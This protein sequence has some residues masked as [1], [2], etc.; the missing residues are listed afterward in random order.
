MKN[1]AILVIFYSTTCWSGNTVI[2]N[3]TDNITLIKFLNLNDS[4]IDLVSLEKMLSEAITFRSDTKLKKLKSLFLITARHN[5]IKGDEYAK[6]IIMS[7]SK[8]DYSYMMAAEW[9]AMRGEP[10]YIYGL[11]SNITHFRYVWALA[12]G[13]DYKLAEPFINKWIN[14]D[15]PLPAY[16]IKPFISNS[17]P[18][19]S[20]LI[21]KINLDLQ[22]TEMRVF[23]S[24]FS[25]FIENE[26][27]WSEKSHAEIERQILKFLNSENSNRIKFGLIILN[28]LSFKRSI[29]DSIKTK[30]LELA[31]NPPSADVMKL[32]YKLVN[33]LM[34]IN[35]KSSI[36]SES[37]NNKGVDK[38]K[39]ISG[40]T[41]RE[42]DSLARYLMNNEF[43]QTWQFLA[44]DLKPKGL[45]DVIISL[46]KGE[47]YDKNG[48]F[49]KKIEY[50]VNL[51]VFKN[52]TDLVKY[53]FYYNLPKIKDLNIIETLKII[54]KNLNSLEQSYIS[55]QT[56]ELFPW[57]EIDLKQISELS[58]TP[59]KI[60]FWVNSINANGGNISFSRNDIKH[61]NLKSLNII[62]SKALAVLK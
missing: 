30:I 46:E 25:I 55:S 8:S 23:D 52:S 13:G 53:H 15:K 22:S 26:N 2:D 57:S 41:D 56:P 49:K 28:E 16:L 10:K 35:T 21:K 14:G 9:L 59:L 36:K 31:L 11:L 7:R 19:K 47:F 4:E 42:V 3:F 58:Q 50:M 60:A 33:N 1:L 40:L 12:S 37:V 38:L 54:H 48:N 45:F 34:L 29:R 51:D 18:F 5:P 20:S 24:A 39:K 44:N 27:I 61:L 62:K 6:K 32:A 17:S 43:S